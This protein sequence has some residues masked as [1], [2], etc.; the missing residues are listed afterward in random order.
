M[1]ERRYGRSRVSIPASVLSGPQMA[2]GREGGEAVRPV[3]GPGAVEPEQA[4]MEERAGATPEPAHATRLEAPGDDR[5][6]QQRPLVDHVD[7][8]MIGRWSKHTRNNA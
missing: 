4:E 5:L 3:A 2:R 8:Q 6:Q 7:P 1:N